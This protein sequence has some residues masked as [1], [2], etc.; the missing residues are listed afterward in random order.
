MGT[1]TCQKP[2]QRTAC[3][4][5]PDVPSGL[6]MAAQKQAR[7]LRWAADAARR[8]PHSVYADWTKEARGSL[9]AAL[10]DPCCVAIESDLV[11]IILA[12]DR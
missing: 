1:W 12:A 6:E 10:G 7:R 2:P 9:E 4:E 8:T 3:G 5:R 11:E